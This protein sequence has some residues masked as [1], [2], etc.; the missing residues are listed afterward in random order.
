[1]YVFIILINSAILIFLD[2]YF[3]TKMVEKLLKFNTFLFSI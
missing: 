2:I 3:I 1:M